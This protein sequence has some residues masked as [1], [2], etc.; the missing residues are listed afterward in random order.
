[1]TSKLDAPS[2]LVKPLIDYPASRMR[3]PCA[4]GTIADRLRWIME[5]KGISERKLSTDAG[6]S[7]GH[8]NFTLKQFAKNPDA[9]I[10]FA[11]IQKLALAGGVSV[12]WLSTG[13]GSPDDNDELPPST[14][15]D[16]APHVNASVPGWDDACVAT[17]RRARGRARAAPRRATAPSASR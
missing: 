16:D 12:R 14:A 9:G 17:P 8:V 4:V 11:T 13:V 2:K 10:E 6:L 15:P 3:Y 7:K 5:T 1:M